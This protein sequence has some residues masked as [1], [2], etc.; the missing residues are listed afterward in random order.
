MSAVQRRAGRVLVIDDTGR[1]LLL[2]GSDP[3]RPDAGSWW[4]TPG[5]GLN[6][7]ETFAEAAR[8]ELAEE[9][10]HR[11]A[12]FGEPVHH[13]TTEFEFDGVRYRQVEQYFLLRVPQLTLDVSAWSDVEQR[14]ISGWLW[15]TAQEMEALTD[16]VYPPECSD[17]LRRL[18]D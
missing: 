3:G 6:D 11:C 1:A 14:S 10:G 12:P 4:F 16:P 8:R 17:L 18:A 5:G 15:C 7:D 13:R 9:T 2:H